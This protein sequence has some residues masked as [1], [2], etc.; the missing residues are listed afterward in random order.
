MSKLIDAMAMPT[1]QE[2]VKAGAHVGHA[3]DKWNPRMAP[4]VF[5]VRNNMHI[6]DVY[7]TLE[8]L[9]EALA[10]LKEQ[11]KAGK[12]ILFVGAKVETRAIVKRV[13]QN[14]DSPYVVGRW[15]GGLFT[16]YGVV[17]KRIEYFKDLEKR[18]SDSDEMEKYTKKEQLS[19]ERQLE[20]M[21][22]E[23][24]GI[25]NLT[26]L[27]DVLMVSDV[28]DEK[29]AVDEA[30][31]LDIP[32]VAL[33]DTNGDPTA[34]AY[35][36]PVNDSALDSLNLIYKTLEEELIVVRPQAA[37]ADAQ[38]ETAEEKKEGVAV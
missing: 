30:R 35:P 34:V 37:E 33:V 38:N 6:I 19:M 24:G 3:K 18:V 32:V 21:Q 12:T 27:P 22:E 10:F 11:R 23:L 15:L 9:E 14:L 16:N 31:A 13:A 8:K 7:K 17:K 4:F 26:E 36:I 20:K 25:K 2:L 1:P 29:I 28:E 5:G